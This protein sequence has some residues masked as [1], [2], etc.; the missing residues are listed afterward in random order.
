[1]QEL[2]KQL[3]RLDTKQHLN[4]L[5]EEMKKQMEQF[6]R[7]MEKMQNPSFAPMV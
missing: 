2:H 4:Q 3:D 7:E 6:R 1:M 5:Q